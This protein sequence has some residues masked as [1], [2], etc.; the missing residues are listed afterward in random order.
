[1]SEHGVRTLLLPVVPD[2]WR[3]EKAPLQVQKIIEIE[4]SAKQVDAGL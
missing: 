4:L 1:M 3:S 2:T